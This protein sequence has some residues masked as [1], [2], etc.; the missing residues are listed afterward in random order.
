MT[1]RAKKMELK[2]GAVRQIKVIDIEAPIRFDVD[3]G[4]FEYEV[5]VDEKVSIAAAAVA[6]GPLAAPG[7]A[8][9]SEIR[10]TCLTAGTL[11]V[12][13]MG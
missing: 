6:T 11:Y 13:H 8:W 2:A 4:S 7:G 5:L 12:V 1:V 9:G 10:I 3:S